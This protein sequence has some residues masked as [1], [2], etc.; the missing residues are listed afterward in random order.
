MIRLT[1]CF[2]DAPNFL[3]MAGP[4][5]ERGEQHPAL[6]LPFTKQMHCDKRTEDNL[7]I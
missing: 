2:G 5:S 6:M 1:S 3:F 4:D 7:K